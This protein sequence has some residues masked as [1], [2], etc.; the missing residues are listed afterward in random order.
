MKRILEDQKKRI[1]AE[2]DKSPDAQMNRKMV[3]PG[4][5][6]VVKTILN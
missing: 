4:T 1:L 3:T 2:L 6:K 5:V